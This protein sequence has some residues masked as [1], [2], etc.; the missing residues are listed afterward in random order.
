LGRTKFLVGDSLRFGNFHEALETIPQKLQVLPL[1]KAPANYTGLVG[2][3]QLQGK[4]LLERTYEGDALF[5]EFILSGRGGGHGWELPR[6][7]QEI[8][9]TVQ[10]KVQNWENGESDFFTEIRI[11][12]SL[13]SQGSSTLHL[14]PL[15]TFSF[16]PRTASFQELTWEHPPVFLL[17]K[18]Q[19]P[20]SDIEKTESLPDSRGSSSFRWGLPLLA[21]G[22]V[23]GLLG[24][25]V[26]VSLRTKK[27]KALLL[28]LETR[29]GKKRGAVLEEYL[30][31]RGIALSD[32]K[33]LCKV[34]Q[35]FPNSRLTEI[36]SFHSPK[37]QKVFYQIEQKLQEQESKDDNRRKR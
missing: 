19:K 22:V 18:A 12:A 36:C 13:S 30:V 20:R 31:S 6:E 26:F 9:R 4:L 7:Y 37:D 5:F 24:R 16:S 23:A 21:L 17:P 8:Q 3:Y 15:R 10:R 25:L 32:A 28:A 35:G 14:P 33:F 1:P 2:E 11:R 34:Y 29:V 27:E